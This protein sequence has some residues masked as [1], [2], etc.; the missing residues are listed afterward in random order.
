MGLTVVSF[1]SAGTET[2]VL[3]SFASVI[4]PLC[5]QIIDKMNAPA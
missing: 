4:L 5:M 2:K 3:A 1:A